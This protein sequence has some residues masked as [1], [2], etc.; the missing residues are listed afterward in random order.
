M[1]VLEMEGKNE[2]TDYL[3]ELAD[4]PPINRGVGWYWRR[5]G[6]LGVVWIVVPELG[7]YPLVG[8]IL[9][10]IDLCRHDWAVTGRYV[11]NDDPNVADDSMFSDDNDF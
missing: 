7:E 11:L 1:K 6:E 4:L 2:M 5:C 3:K 8:H 9:D 10:G